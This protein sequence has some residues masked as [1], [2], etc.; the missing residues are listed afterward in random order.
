MRPTSYRIGSQG[1]KPNI[2]KSVE[3]HPQLSING[4]PVDGVLMGAGSLWLQESWVAWFPS[5]IQNMVRHM[6]N[7][8][9]RFCAHMKDL[10]QLLHKGCGFFCG[11]FLT[12]CKKHY[13]KTLEIHIFKCKISFFSKG[14][15][16]L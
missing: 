7:P 10:L 6:G 15:P 1:E 3:V 2:N 11:E 4:H 14:F 12:F 13:D 9:T 8:L 5:P 16:L